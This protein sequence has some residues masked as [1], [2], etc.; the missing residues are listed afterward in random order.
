MVSRGPPTSPAGQPAGLNLESRLVLPEAFERWIK[1]R[2]TMQIADRVIELVS[3]WLTSINKRKVRV[4]RGTLFRYP[5]LVVGALRWEAD[6]KKTHQINWQ[7]LPPERLLLATPK[8]PPKSTI[9]GRSTVRQERFEYLSRLSPVRWWE[10][11]VLGERVYVVAEFRS[12]AIAECIKDGNAA[13]IVATTQDW[14]MILGKTKAEA[15]NLG[16]KRIVHSGNW[17]ERMLL[18]ILYPNKAP[19]P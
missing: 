4:D 17:R 2:K 15:R 18:E 3:E 12:V 13:Y 8:R 5:H 16:A 19:N 11:E 9:R 14:K 1:E 7:I 10:G 6:G